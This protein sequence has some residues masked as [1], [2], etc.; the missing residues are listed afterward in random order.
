MGVIFLIYCVFGNILVG[1]II[2][3]IRKNQVI[4]QAVKDGIYKLKDTEN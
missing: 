3:V 4:K 1:G 2:A